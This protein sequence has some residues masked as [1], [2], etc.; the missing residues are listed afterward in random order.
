[1]AHDSTHFNEEAR[2]NE[3]LYLE[4]SSEQQEWAQN[5]AENLDYYSG[6][7]WTAEQRSA[8]LERGQQPIAIQTIYQVVEQAIGMLSANRPGFRAVAR[9]DSDSKTATMISDLFQWMWQQSKGQQRFTNILRDNYVQGRGVA[10]AYIDWDADFG[11]G[12]VKFM[13]LDPKEV[14][15]DP[16]STDPLLDDAAF[17]IVRRL[18]TFSQ[19]REMWGEEKAEE[20]RRFGNQ[21][22][23]YP[24]SNSK[25]RTDNTRVHPYDI[26]TWFYSKDGQDQYEIIECFKRIKKRFHRL[27]NPATGVEEI[28]PDDK[29]QERLQAS[30]YLITERGMERMVTD[31]K[32]VAAQDE[33]YGRLG[34]VYHLMPGA[35]EVAE[36]GEMIPAMP[37]PVS[38]S[39]DMHYD[40]IP[41]STVALVPTTIGEL[42]GQG[43]IPTVPFMENRIRVVTTSGTMMVHDP[44]ELPTQH[45]PLVFFPNSS[46]RNPYPISDV[47]RLKDLQ[48][49]INKSQSLILAHLATSTNM[50]VFY[51]EGSIKNKAA[52]EQEWSKAGAAMIP[53]DPA[54]GIGGDSPGGIKLAPPPPL[55][56]A[57]YANID[58]A[59][60]MMERIAGVYA[61]QQGETIGQTSQTFRGTLAQDEFATRRMKHKLDVIYGSLERLGVVMLDYA[62]YVYTDKKVI[63]LLNASGEHKQSTM[64]DSLPFT[65]YTSEAEKIND[66]T[67]GRYDVMILGGSTLPSNRWSKH[68]TYMEMFDRGIVDD[69][70]VLRSAEIADAE[71]ILA[72]KSMYSEL[73]SANQ[74]L[75]EQLKTIQGDLQTADRKAV[76]AEQKTLLAKF[77]TRLA[78]IEAG[79]SANAQVHNVVVNDLTNQARQQQ[80]QHLSTQGYP[81]K[82][83]QQQQNV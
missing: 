82:S 39:E 25:Y 61:T 46:N 15:P 10:Y 9:E 8:L 59:V 42:V 56:A 26:A 65:D 69:F 55:P 2:E 14:F 6:N 62:Q 64:N 49:M 5:A 80:Q 27:Y 54:F 16:R 28:L 79:I 3:N 40:A 72:R 51:P 77:A 76:N 33:I 81:K 24:Y 66:I 34:P 32:E 60:A 45:Y 74:Q 43:V 17:I 18:F 48:D 63:R 1:M 35:S 30:A 31:P 75:E 29:Y 78:K 73:R 68:A 52:I 12:E 36:T 11:K 23:D 20:V 58:R 71:E 37:E 4:A 19:M 53:Y 57:L 83:N 67:R 70:A 13:D 7:H 47:D 22:N 38:G 41:G 44:Y 21:R 50:K